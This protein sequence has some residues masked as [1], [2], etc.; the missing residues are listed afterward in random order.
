MEV[1]AEVRLAL[2]FVLS[3]LRNSDVSEYCEQN[4]EFHLHF[5]RILSGDKLVTQINDAPESL[6]MDEFMD[7]NISDEERKSFRQARVKLRSQM[8]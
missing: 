4:K 6:V 5:E 1:H 3:N 8:L 7:V 2:N